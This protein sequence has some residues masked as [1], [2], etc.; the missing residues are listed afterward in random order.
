[1]PKFDFL[2]LILSR[3]V[4]STL[5]H[6]WAHAD[7][8]RTASEINFVNQTIS[9]YIIWGGGNLKEEF[10]ALDDLD[11]FSKIVVTKLLKS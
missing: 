8:K 7:N 5:H 9:I 1:M 4:S 6:Q 11:Y 10:K 3:S 2:F